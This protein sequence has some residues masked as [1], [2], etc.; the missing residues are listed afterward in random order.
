MHGRTGYG[1]LRQVRQPLHGPS[2]TH[3]VQ[4][5]KYADNDRCSQQCTLW[6]MG[7]EKKRFNR[8]VGKARPQK[9]LRPVQNTF[10][11]LWDTGQKRSPFGSAVHRS[12]VRDYPRFRERGLGFRVLGYV[13]KNKIKTGVFLFPIRIF[14]CLVNCFQGIL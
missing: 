9:L 4:G 7:G 13:K 14:F 10:C 11:V 5:Q 8:R 6:E 1:D 12:M 2:H 3:Q